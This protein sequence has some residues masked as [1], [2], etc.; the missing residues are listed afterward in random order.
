VPRVEARLAGRKP[1]PDLRAMWR[2]PYLETCCRSALHRVILTGEGGRPPG[3][4]D[5][6]CLDRLVTLGL[7]ASGAD[8]RFFATHKGRTRHCSEIA[9]GAPYGAGAEH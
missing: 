7:V 3:L 8:G 2:E 5:Q 4:S 6:P 9:P 1:L